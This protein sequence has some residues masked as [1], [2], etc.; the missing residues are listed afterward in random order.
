MRISKGGKKKNVEKYPT[1]E[2][3]ETYVKKTLRKLFGMLNGEENIITN[4]EEG[5]D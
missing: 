2:N 3:K 5:I 4:L 1:I